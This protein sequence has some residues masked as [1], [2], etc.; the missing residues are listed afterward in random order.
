MSRAPRIVL[1][2]LALGGCALKSDVRRLESQLDIMRA[3]A[4][5]QDSARAFQL[6]ELI[7][8]Q[9]RIMDSLAASQQL[10]RGLAGNLG[11]DLYNVQQQ[12]VQIQ[13]LQGQ[14]QRRLTEIRT[15]LE[16]RREQL[17]S[18]AAP[19]AGA[20]ADTAPPARVA[21]ADQMYEASVQQLRRGSNATARLGF[22]E[23]L[24]VH[25][26]SER[27]PDALYFLGETF[28][29]ESP[30]SAAHYWTQ[31]VDDYPTSARAATALYKLGLLAEQRRDVAA[32]RTTYQRVVKEYPKSDEAA[33]AR[34]RLR[35]LGR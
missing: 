30:D 26:T 29:T 31:V 9:R 35:A 8:L 27:V 20:R 12:L 14:S 22:R 28:A 6:N 34:D 10:V 13:E 4:A 33:L 32:A 5:R 17:D 16:A 24:R 18:A 7:Q 2:V 21:S 15:Q 11:N 23:L 3:E 1:A 19:G 25:P